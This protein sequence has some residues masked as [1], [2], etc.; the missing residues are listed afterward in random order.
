M[1]VYIDSD[2]I[3]DVLLARENFATESGQI[4]NLSEK[5]LISGTTTLLA[6]A[7]IH[8]ILRRYDNKKAIKTIRTLR[9][10]LNVMPL[11]DK[12]LLM[13]LNSNF[14]DFEDA[15]QNS[16]ALSFGCTAII[17]RNIRDYASSELS[18]YSPKEF[19]LQS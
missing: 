14:K 4:L 1:K 18:I 8:Y 12:E 6:I 10:I 2:V 5:G 15:I 3:L 16:A 17:T 13:A 7:N 11:T 19:I 9:E